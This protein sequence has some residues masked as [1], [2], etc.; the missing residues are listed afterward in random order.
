MSV[1]ES[2]HHL[3]EAD[4]SHWLTRAASTS[5][6]EQLDALKDEAV[7]QARAHASEDV[8]GWV[9]D[10]VDGYD[11]RVPSGIGD[12]L[13]LLHSRQTWHLGNAIGDAAMRLHQAQ[14]VVPEL[15]PVTNALR[16]SCRALGRL[17]LLAGGLRIVLDRSTASALLPVLAGW[18][19]RDEA[20]TRIA[21]VQLSW[22]SKL[23]GRHKALAA[24]TA[25]ERVWERWQSMCEAIAAVAAEGGL[26]V[27]A[28]EV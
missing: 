28:T 22:F 27:W 24:W 16:G 26:L 12:L 25:D 19:T 20:A 13:M 6:N 1:S 23:R 11:G 9:R 18:T 5:T 10:H 8:R 4:L 21:A 3:D 2:L 14:S 17:G 7:A 15:A